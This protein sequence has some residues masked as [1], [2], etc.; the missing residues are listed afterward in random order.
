MAF[1]SYNNSIKVE[2][3]TYY[4]IPMV[5]LVTLLR[6]LP[7]RGVQ[8]LHISSIVDTSNVFK[9]TFQT[10]SWYIGML[11]LLIYTY[12]ENFYI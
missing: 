1:R 8:T 4:C 3:T 2:K 10:N 6:N 7:K 12:Y 11:F 9:N 5:K